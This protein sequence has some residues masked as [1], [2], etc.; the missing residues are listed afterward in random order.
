MD[1]ALR[2]KTGVTLLAIKRG[3]ELLEHPSPDTIFRKDDIA[4]VM[5]EKE[6][7]ELATEMLVNKSSVN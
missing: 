1:I 3:K 2:K 7:I 4:Y 5:G 6:Q